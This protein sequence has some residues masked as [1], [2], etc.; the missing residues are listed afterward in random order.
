MLLCN[1]IL[2]SRKNVT[3]L[4]LYLI[5]LRFRILHL[6]CKSFSGFLPTKNTG[7]FQILTFEILMKCFKT[8][9]VVSYEQP[10]PGIICTISGSFTV[11]IV[12]KLMQTV[13]D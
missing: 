4:F 9:D 2:Q 1:F 8:N 13:H 12:K 11:R 10:G 6:H 5:L 3:N 7:I